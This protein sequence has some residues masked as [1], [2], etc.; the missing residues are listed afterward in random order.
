MD[1]FWNTQSAMNVS[2]NSTSGIIDPIDVND[3]F[4]TTTWPSSLRFSFETVFQTELAV[5]GGG[6]VGSS[7]D[8]PLTQATSVAPFSI[9]SLDAL[10]DDVLPP[11]PFQQQQLVATTDSHSAETFHDWGSSSEGTD[12]SCAP[13]EQ[14]GSYELT[15]QQ[16]VESEQQWE[17]RLNQLYRSYTP[18]DEGVETSLA[19]V[20]KDVDSKLQTIDTLLDTSV[21]EVKD[22]YTAL[23]LK[24]RFATVLQKCNVLQNAVH[25]SEPQQLVSLVWVTQPLP[26]SFKNKNRARITNK[27]KKGHCSMQAQLVKAPGVEFVPTSQVTAYFYLNAEEHASKTAKARSRRGTKRTKDQAAQQQLERSDVQI[28]NN[29]EELEDD[30]VTFNFR[31]PAGTRNKPCS[32]RLHVRGLVHMADGTKREVEV[33]SEPTHRFIVTTNECQYEGA[34]LKLMAMEVF[35]HSDQDS[36][37]WARFVNAL[38]VRWMRVTRQESDSS[39][40]CLEID[41]TLSTADLEYFAR[42]FFVD[43]ADRHV[44]YSQLVDFYAFFG[45]VTHV[46]RHNGPMRTL[47]R[48]GL[49]WGFL[50]KQDATQRLASLQPGSFIIRVSEVDP[51]SFAVSWHDPSTLQVRHAHLEDKLLSSPHVGTIADYIASKPFL[52]HVLTPFMRADRETID[53]PTLRRKDDAF[54]KF[55]MNAKKSLSLKKKEAITNAVAVIVKDGYDD[56]EGYL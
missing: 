56:I 35:P 42:R 6:G 28:Q 54:G 55:Y 43:S 24:D 19:I 4:S 49:I 36:C 46:Y 7:S 30:R 2:M 10:V 48:E 33:L 45:K 32:I 27:K 39:V 21:L 53:R 44:V 50:S 16:L 52:Q 13:M 22:L 40:E 5:A 20:K 3:D 18:G 17:D 1:D 47:L 41:R 9:A 31:F 12:L 51:G 8:I 14:D 37:S 29:V 23:S 11:F 34:E 15:L 38:S 25:E 26:R